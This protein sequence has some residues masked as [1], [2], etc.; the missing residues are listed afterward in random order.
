VSSRGSRSTLRA[1]AALLGS[2]VLALTLAQPTMGLTRDRTPPTAPTGLTVQSVTT[3]TATISWSP[4]TDN[5][6]IRS[7]TVC[8][9]L[10]GC[11]SVNHPTTQAV[12]TGLQEGRSVLALAYATDTS[13]NISGW[14]DS[15]TVTTTSDDPAPPAPSDLTVV[16]TGISTVEL[17]WTPSTRTSR[18]Y[19]DVLVNGVP[20]PNAVSTTSAGTFPRPTLVGAV[21]RQLDP[22]T[23][24]T[25]SVRARAA[26]GLVSAE[27][28]TVTATTGASNDTVPPSPPPVLT[29]VQAG[30]TGY[31]PEEVW[32]R[33]QPSVDN[34]GFVEY[35]V[36]F[37]GLIEDVTTGA[38]TV[39]YTEIQGPFAVTIVA[40]DRAGNASAPS[41]AINANLTQNPCPF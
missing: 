2:A 29:S 4:S 8:A 28:N 39:T 15:V 25:F 9:L 38:G 11:V 16:R 17:R 21:A 5:R 31:C 33:W 37:N 20:T 27:T 34:S 22:S 19:Y 12:L 35:E 1:L 32:L 41:N 26:S 3:T 14:S 10:G 36:R 7:Y 18:V 23:T 30:M 13:G 6:G 40:V 24:Y